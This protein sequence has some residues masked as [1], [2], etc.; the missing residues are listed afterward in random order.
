MRAHREYKINCVFSSPES[1]IITTT[2]VLVDR[3]GIASRLVLH[4]ALAMSLPETTQKYNITITPFPLQTLYTT[5]S[6]KK[7]RIARLL[8]WF[9]PVYF[10]HMAAMF[11]MLVEDP[12][13]QDPQPPG[14]LDP[15][16]PIAVLFK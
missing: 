15:Q 9:Q 7:T 5:I 11:C 4:D 6:T 3:V 10:W 14:Q 8:T 2:S 13:G 16:F 12:Q 1:D